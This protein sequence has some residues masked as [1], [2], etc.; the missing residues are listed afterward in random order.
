MEMKTCLKP[1]QLCNRTGYICKGMQNSC[2]MKIENMLKILWQL[3]ENVHFVL[4][5]ETKM[6]VALIIQIESLVFA[7]TG[8]VLFCLVI[9]VKTWNKLC[10]G[11]NE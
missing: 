1:T 4:E 10:A 8:R 2:D 5:M 6:T 7:G 11:P 9:G 3:R